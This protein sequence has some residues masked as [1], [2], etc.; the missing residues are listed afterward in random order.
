MLFNEQSPREL[1]ISDLQKAFF[2][3]VDIASSVVYRI[4][5]GIIMLYEVYRYF[6]YDWISRYWI[7][8]ANNFTYWPFD[9]VKPL[10]GETMYYVFYLMGI[11]SIFIIVGYRYRL[12]SILFFLVFSYTFLLE[13]TRYMNHFYLVCLLGF[14]NCF[15]PLEKEWSLDAKR[16]PQKASS[17]VHAWVLYLIQAMIAIPYFF[18]GVAKI[19]PD[20]FRG[21][22]LDIWLSP[23]LDIP[24]IGPFLDEQ[25]M[26]LLLSYSGLLLDLLIVP[27]LIY[28][29]TRLPAFIFITLFHLMNSQFFQIGIFPWFMIGASTIFFR[30]DW[31]RRFLAKLKFL[32]QKAVAGRPLALH[33]P[34][35]RT[36]K[37][38]TVLLCAWLLLH[39]FLPFRH[40]LYPGNVSW[41]EEG[42]RFAWH[43]K[44]RTKRGKGVFRAVDRQTGEV[45]RIKGKDYM[46][47]WQWNKAI[48]R[49]YLI[50]QFARII[51]EDFAERG[52]DVAVFADLKAKLNG[53]P[54]QQFTD[55]EIDLTSVPRP[56]FFHSEWILPL[57]TPLPE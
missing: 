6:K 16:R 2:R 43:M 35:I 7:E 34:S 25:W 10:P 4:W 26:I 50:W 20:W 42:H 48:V 38:I 17:H 51:Q 47:R 18:G 57:E 9:F 24:L 15:L 5:F 29:R 53:R 8:P 39:I 27:A 36:Q 3:P 1:K 44:L 46:D 19:N 21:K 52:I 14:V 31:P 32:N 13:Q 55:P 33:A 12:S 28:K 54:Y 30:P 56:I 23:E 41:T 22:P 11:L 49:P 40:H 45:Y 37:T